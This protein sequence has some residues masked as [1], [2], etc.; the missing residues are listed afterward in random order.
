MATLA[1]GVLFSSKHKEPLDSFLTCNYIRFLV[2]NIRDLFVILL[3][4]QHFGNLLKVR[5]KVIMEEK[6]HPLNLYFVN[7]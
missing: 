7:L 2:G 5:S 6:N 3:Q 1:L 4:L